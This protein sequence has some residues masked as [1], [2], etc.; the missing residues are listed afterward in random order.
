MR[1]EEN[2]RPLIRRNEIRR[3]TY[4]RNRHLPRLQRNREAKLMHRDLHLGLTIALFK[5]T[6]MGVGFIILHLLSN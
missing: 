3:H 5:L 1:R 6:C 4:H 2:H